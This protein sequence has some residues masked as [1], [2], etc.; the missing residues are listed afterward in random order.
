M[1]LSFIV[2]LS[3]SLL[4][5]FAG[6]T[7]V[8]NLSLTDIQGSWNIQS[9]YDTSNNNWGQ[10][11]CVELSFRIINSSAVLMNLFGYD[12]ARNSTF[13]DSSMLYPDP[14]NPAILYQDPNRKEA[15]LM[16][17]NVTSMPYWAGGSTPAMIFA[18]NYTDSVMVLGGNKWYD[19][20]YDIRPYVS[21]QGLPVKSS[22]NLWF[23]NSACDAH[24]AWKPVQGFSSSSLLKTFNLIAVY[25]PAG[26]GTVPWYNGSG[27]F[28]WKQAYC[29]KVSFSQP[30][31][32]AYSMNMN[33]Q[34]LYQGNFT[35]T[36]QVTPY[37]QLQSIL[38]GFD[39]SGPTL[40]YVVYTDTIGNLILASGTTTAFY[41]STSSN[42]YTSVNKVLFQNVLFTMGIKPNF[43]FIYPID[44]SSC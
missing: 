17:V 32:S 8:T 16:V 36:W 12:G 6:F 30:K 11:Y 22:K 44:G 23:I 43:N 15:P 28:P 7:P 18:F 40:L 3:M 29:A 4:C 21:A 35:R 13:N 25:D 37:P 2:F 33:I 5:A 41:L 42:Q 1:N 20:L 34:S 24:F 19:N 26:T 9:V 31:R 39:I 10:A 38:M 27:I 14:K